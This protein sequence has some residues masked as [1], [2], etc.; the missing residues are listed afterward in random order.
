MRVLERHKVSYQVHR[1][2]EDIHSATGVADHLG[3]DYQAVYKT[4]VLERPAGGKRLLILVA[5][6]RTLNLKK[7]AQCLSEKRLRMATQAEAERL[8]GLKVGGISPLALLNRGF[9]IFLDRQALTQDGV[10]V[11]AGQRGVNLWLA[12]ADL[13][14]VTGAAIV[15][16]S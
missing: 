8:T 7:L 13:V 15:E 9:Q 11:S 1:F 6:D 12:P 10:L 5:A 4:L 16:A 3:I 2:P 14:R